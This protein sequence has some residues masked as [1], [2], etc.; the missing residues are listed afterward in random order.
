MNEGVLKD[1]GGAA[2]TFFK[3]YFNDL[4]AP[5]ILVSFVSILYFIT[6]RKLL[7]NFWWSLLLVAFAS[8]FWEYVTPLYKASTSDLW[9]L[10]AYLVG[11]L[12]YWVIVKIVLKRA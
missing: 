11:F 12:V 3:G 9:D 8:L 10:L 6:T 2:G 7:I 5:I 4:L 1:T